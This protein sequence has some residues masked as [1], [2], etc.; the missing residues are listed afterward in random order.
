VREDIFT[1]LED[2]R[3][4]GW[5]SDFSTFNRFGEFSAGLRVVDIDADFE[6]QLDGP[7]IRYVY[8]SDDPR[9]PGQQYIVWLPEVIESSL[10]ERGTNSPPML[11][12][13]VEAGRFEL[14]PGLRVDRDAFSEET[15]VAPA[16]SV[17]LRRLTGPALFLTSGLYYESPRF[18][19]RAANPDNF[20]LANEEIAHFGLGLDYDNQRA[21]ERDGRGL[22][23]A[24]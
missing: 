19:V 21:L 23:P 8:E 1:I 15:Y 6:T 7:W 22:L 10:S 3:E 12:Q 13:V 20:D 18:L 14:R 11:E 2:E 17:S 24:A 5:R 4:L 9:P 16:W